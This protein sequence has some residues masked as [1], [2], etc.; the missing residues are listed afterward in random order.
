MYAYDRDYLYHAQR[1]FGHM[2]D[3][4]VNTCDMDIDEYFNI[5]LEPKLGAYATRFAFFTHG[6]KYASSLSDI[7]IFH[8]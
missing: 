3:F 1:N 4:A 6:K 7:V 5:F 2:V 8:I